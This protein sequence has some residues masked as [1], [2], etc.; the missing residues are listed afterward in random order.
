MSVTFQ[1][2]GQTI[3]VED[4]GDPESPFLNVNNRNGAELLWRLGLDDQELYGELRAGEFKKRC[5]AALT[6]PDP[7]IKAHDGTGA[8]GA[9]WHDM[10]R[11]AGRIHQH[12]QHLAKIA[13]DAGELGVICW[14]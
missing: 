10:G 1:V 7:G 2:K 8:K 14:G 11:P 13:E 6:Q 9:R 4:L 5:E 12:L 3:D